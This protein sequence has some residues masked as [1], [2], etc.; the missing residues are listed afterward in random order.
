LLII[1]LNNLQNKDGK[2]FCPF[3]IVVVGGGGGG[4]VNKKVKHNKN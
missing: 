2:L 3:C 1:K 4:S